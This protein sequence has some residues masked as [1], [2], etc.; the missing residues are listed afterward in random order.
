[1]QDWLTMSAPIAGR[2]I[3]RRGALC[4][5]ALT[6]AFLDASHAHPAARASMPG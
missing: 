1:M 5:V 3:D 6:E 2:A 4:P